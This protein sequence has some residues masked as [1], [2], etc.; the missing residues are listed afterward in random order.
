MN[1]T[2]GQT[3]EAGSP[4]SL[5][6]SSNATMAHKPWTVSHHGDSVIIIDGDSNQVGIVNRKSNADSIVRAVNEHAAL[7]AVAEAARE[8]N[9]AVAAMDTSYKTSDFL[10]GTK[11]RRYFRCLKASTD[12]VASLTALTER[13]AK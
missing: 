12:A 13:G 7:V 4:A 2:T 5:R 1:A 6:A 11:Q 3:K 8:L 10:P 9:S